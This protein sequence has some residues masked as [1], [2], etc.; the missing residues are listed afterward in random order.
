MET[1]NDLKVRPVV[2][3]APSQHLSELLEQIL[4]P[5]VPYQKSFNKDNWDFIRKIQSKL[6]YP[7]K[8]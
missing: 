3:N 7:C 2:A 5:P 1:P 6:D 8:L 4:Q